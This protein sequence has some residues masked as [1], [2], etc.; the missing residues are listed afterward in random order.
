MDKPK[1]WTSFDVCNKLK[2][3]LKV[4]KVSLA[5]AGAAPLLPCKHVT[6]PFN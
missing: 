5:C 1:T 6:P 2:G 3:A 4:K